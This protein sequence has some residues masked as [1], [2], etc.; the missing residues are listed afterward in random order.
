[1]KQ[2]NGADLVLTGDIP[3]GICGY[4]GYSESLTKIKLSE[5][6]YRPHCFWM[7]GNEDNNDKFPQSVVFHLPDFLGYGNHTSAADGDNAAICAVQ[8]RLWKYDHWPKVFPIFWPPLVYPPIVDDPTI[9]TGL[10]D[11]QEWNYLDVNYLQN[12]S[13]WLNKS[14]SSPWK[15]GQNGPKRHSVDLSV[16]KGEADKNVVQE[17]GPASP[18]ERHFYRN[19]KMHDVTVG[20]SVSARYACENPNMIGPDVLSHKEQLYCDLD[21][22]TLYTFCERE[23][24]NKEACFDEEKMELVGEEADEGSDVFVQLMASDAG[25]SQSFTKPRLV[26]KKLV[27][28]LNVDEAD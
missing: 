7:T 9:P 4:H 27:S 17:R 24:N 3:A 28:P 10:L 13:N 25:L 6:H 11:V 15:R 8:P 19:G 5:G 22:H 21:T 26:R 18:R 2:P 14:D 12:S 23:A 20:A 1:M 16:F